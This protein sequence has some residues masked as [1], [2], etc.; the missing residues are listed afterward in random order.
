MI[1]LSKQKIEKNG[2]K[3][4]TAQVIDQN[5]MS[6]LQDASFTHIL[7]GLGINFVKDAD[8][9]LQGKFATAFSRL[10]AT[11]SLKGHC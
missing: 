9:V 3:G 1:D 10:R 5:D 6:S 2:W 11:T 4:V 8:A 7:T